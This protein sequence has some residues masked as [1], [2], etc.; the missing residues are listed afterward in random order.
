MAQIAD[1]PASGPGQKSKSTRVYSRAE[2]RDV[3]AKAQAHHAENAN[4]M[5][6][7]A[8]N[9]DGQ[10]AEELES[11]AVSAAART[12]QPEASNATA[13]AADKKEARTH[14]SS[15]DSADHILHTH[16]R[17]KTPRAVTQ[18]HGPLRNL[19]GRGSWS[20]GGRTWKPRASDHFAARPWGIEMMEVEAGAA[21]YRNKR[22]EGASYAHPPAPAGGRGLP[23][24]L[25]GAGTGT[26]RPRAGPRQLAARAYGLMSSSIADW[27]QKG[28]REAQ[29]S[30]D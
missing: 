23:H 30:Q 7:T 20:F 19:P 27:G 4:R 24:P 3:T 15:C 12:E 2:V 16:T 5:T 17:H 18:H 28:Q 10:H 6:E 9:A 11:T 25:R 22:A 29:N 8:A 13:V 21:I 1:K 26:D 14:N